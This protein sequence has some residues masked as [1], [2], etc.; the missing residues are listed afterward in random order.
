P[1][2]SP[3]AI[4]SLREQSPNARQSARSNRRRGSNSQY[5]VDA[6]KYYKGLKIQILNP[7]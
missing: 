3:N 1:G 5:N 2:S 6:F 7:P 4:L